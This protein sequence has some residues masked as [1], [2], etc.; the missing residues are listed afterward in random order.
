M[1]TTKPIKKKTR[2][3]RPV[4]KKGKS[5]SSKKKNTDIAS[6]ETHDGPKLKIK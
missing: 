2:L 5:K 1:S 6:I 3:D 4:A